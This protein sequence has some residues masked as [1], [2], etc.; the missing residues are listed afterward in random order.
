MT[1]KIGQVMV[2]VDDLASAK[3]F[4]CDLIG[5][6]LEADL[7]EQANMLI[8]KNDGCYF[9]IHGGF[10]RSP[11]DSDDCRTTIVIAVDDIEAMKAKLIQNGVELIG[12]TEQSPIHRYQFVKDPA[13]NWIEIAQYD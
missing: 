12:E 9:T 10:R 7:A 6:E 1:P 5:I 2:F 8:L 4:Y 13:E 3:Q 11:T